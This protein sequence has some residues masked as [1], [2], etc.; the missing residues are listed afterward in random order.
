MEEYA[1]VKQDFV[2]LT[3]ES[4]EDRDK[5]A[6]KDMKKPPKCEDL[7][8]TISESLVT[9]HFSSQNL[10]FTF[11]NIHTPLKAPEIS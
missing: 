3:P 5:E 4:W 10:A 7:P 2:E 6:M 8:S 11:I 1:C 9:T